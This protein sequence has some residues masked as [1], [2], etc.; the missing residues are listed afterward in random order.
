MPKVNISRTAKLDDA[1]RKVYS[2]F[3]AGISDDQ[4]CKIMG[5]SKPT[6]YKRQKHPEQLT[7]GE[8]RILYREAKLPDEVFMRMIREEPSDQRHN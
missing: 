2:F 5:Y 1:F 3:C 4:A 7:L 8:L 6:H